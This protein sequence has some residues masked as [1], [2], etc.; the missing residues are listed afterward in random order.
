MITKKAVYVAPEALTR[1]YN[2]KN[3]PSVKKKNYR[4][5]SIESIK[6]H[7]L[8]ILSANS[9]RANRQATWKSLEKKVSRYLLHV[10][11]QNWHGCKRPDDFFR[12]H[13]N[14]GTSMTGDDVLSGKL[15]LSVSLYLPELADPLYF[16]TFSQHMTTIST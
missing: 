2:K 12:V 8:S 4:V 7:I 13:C 3:Y 6:T 16:L 9:Q 5:I 11:M 14:L 15:I 1:A 10:W